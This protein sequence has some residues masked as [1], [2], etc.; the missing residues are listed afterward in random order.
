MKRGQEIGLSGGTGRA[1]GPHLDVAVRWQGIYLD[2]GP[3]SANSTAGRTSCR[4]LTTLPRPTSSR[5]GARRLIQFVFQSK[6]PNQSVQIIR[7]HS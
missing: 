2:P 3:P 7:M 6:I 4:T 1:T 5:A